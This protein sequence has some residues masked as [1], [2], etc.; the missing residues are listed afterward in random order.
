M[1]DSYGAGI[2][3]GH[4]IQRFDETCFRY[5]GAYPVILEANLQPRPSRFNFVAC[6]GDKFPAILQSQFRDGPSSLGRP[7]WGNRPEFITL[8]MGGNDIGFK[9]LVSV[10]VYSI[11]IFTLKDCAEV[12]AD[13]QRRLADPDFVRDAVNVISTALRKGSSR[14]GPNF[15]V[16]VTGYAQF[17]NEQNLQCNFVSLKPSWSP[18]A[19][20]YL[21]I[22]LRQALNKI[23]RDLNA[24]LQTAVMRANIGAPRRVFFINY[25]DLFEGHR[26]CDREEPNPNDPE[27]W[28]F[29]LGSNEAEIGQFLN[30]IPRISRL[31][32]GRRDEPVSDQE[33]FRLIGEAAH[34]DERKRD[35]GVAAFRI[36]HPKP[37]GHRA[38]E[39]RLRAA[40]LATTGRIS[41][42]PTDNPIQTS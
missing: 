7:N 36:M 3:A 17:F 1:G 22:D 8:S 11:R 6:S 39:G 27:T 10:C 41:T 29:T 30:S 24:V 14:S 20:Q 13:S 2:G 12:I 4:M 31:L 19:R 16:Y 15:K 33:F 18:F 28:F 25:D 9:E 26:F 23:A 37:L 34:G 32:N 38:I 35:N 40:L 42:G 5:D 21:T